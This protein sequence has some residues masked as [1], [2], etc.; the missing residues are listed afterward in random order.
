[1]RGL[2]GVMAQVV[3]ALN[4]KGITILQTA[5]SNISVSL[6]I[7][8]PDLADAVKT[9]HDHFALGEPNV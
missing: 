3:R 2:P 1:M 5:D 4:G 8:R 9:L 6:L 7:R